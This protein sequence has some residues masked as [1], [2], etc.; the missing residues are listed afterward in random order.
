MSDDDDKDKL[1][2]A[3]DH[4]AEKTGDFRKLHPHAG[5]ILEEIRAILQQSRTGEH[6][7]RISDSYGIRLTVTPEPEKAGF[8]PEENV[9]AV[10]VP[11][12]QN[13]AAARQV[14]DLTAS[15]RDAEQGILGFT[16]DREDLSPEDQQDLNHAKNLD[17]I[18][19]MCKISEELENKAPEVKNELFNMG[20]RPLFQAYK[21]KASDDEMV[22]A[23]KK[24]I[25][26]AKE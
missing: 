13:I 1:L 5:K 24:T 4:S 12:E 18:M 17:M 19:D 21:N 15:L 26:D 11:P 9:I 14:L 10:S 7:L 23:Y 6:L 20:L 3:F 8:I 25:I 2:G 22:E 16:R